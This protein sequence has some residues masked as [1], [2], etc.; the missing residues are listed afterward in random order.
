MP[1]AVHHPKHQH[2]AARSHRRRTWVSSLNDFWDR[3][4]VKPVAWTLAV[5]VWLP[6]L[7]VILTVLGI[8]PIFTTAVTKL[9][10]KALKVPVTL[11]RASVSFS[12]RLRLGPLQI[13]NPPEFTRSEAVSFEGMYAEVPIRSLFSREIEI[14]VLTVVKPVFNLEMGGKKHPSNWAVLMKNLSESLPKKDQPEPADGEKRFIIRD[15]KIVNPVVRYRSP[16]FPD[17]IDLD[18]KDVE[19]KKIGNTPDSRSKTYIVLASIFQAVLTGG[20]KDKH[21]PGEVRGPLSDELGAASKA[22]GEAF[23]GIK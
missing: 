9:G 8:N 19:L 1:T 15:L 6:F 18:L 11:H 21:L 5:L 2:R 20:I 17:G 10:S 13:A 14:P 3:R 16:T 4:G 22:F 12:G 23:G 7:F